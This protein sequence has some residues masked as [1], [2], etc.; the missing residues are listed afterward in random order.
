MVPGAGGARGLPASPFYLQALCTLVDTSPTP[1]PR[2]PCIPVPIWDD[3]GTDHP[4]VRAPASLPR[5]R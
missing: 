3:I 2:F 4:H 1:P 5:W